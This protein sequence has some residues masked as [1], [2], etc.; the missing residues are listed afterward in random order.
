MTGT[1]SLST[2]KKVIKAGI[3]EKLTKHVFNV[4]PK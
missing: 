2:S 4:L 1:K 3:Q